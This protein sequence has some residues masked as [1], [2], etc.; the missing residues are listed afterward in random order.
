MTM[1][2]KIGSGLSTD[3]N[4]VLLSKMTN[5]RIV[6][7][8][9]RDYC[10]TCFFVHGPFRRLFFFFEEGGGGGWDD[11]PLPSP[12]SFNKWRALLSHACTRGVG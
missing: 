3:F 9:L 4:F 5:S 10:L 2:N 12:T 11:S 1:S 8:K 7:K 6:S